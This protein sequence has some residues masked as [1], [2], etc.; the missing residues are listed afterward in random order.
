MWDERGFGVPVGGEELLEIRR[1]L[2]R[3]HALRD[4]LPRS[5]RDVGQYKTI[6]DLQAI[7]PTRIAQSQRRIQIAAWKSNARGR[8]ETLFHDGA[9]RIVRLD[10]FDAARFW[11]LGTRWCTTSDEATFLR[12][13][14]RSPL[15]VFLTPRGKFQLHVGGAF[16]NAENQDASREEF[17]DAPSEFGEIFLRLRG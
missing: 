11:G 16:R 14:R 1:A 8:S 9:W 5:H 10:G 7:V 4:R 3:F 15:V 13:T 12:Y 2:T 6:S 17:S